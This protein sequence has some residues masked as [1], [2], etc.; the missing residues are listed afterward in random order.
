MNS[1]QARQKLLQMKQELEAR[2]A[3]THKHIYNKEE[4]VSPKFSEQ[5]KETENDQLVYTLDR[6]AQDELKRINHA[7]LRIEAGQ[8]F[9]CSRCGTTINAERLQAIPYT[10][11]CIDCA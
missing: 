7:L 10:E 1:D 3:R 9:K 8:Y 11:F 6:E 4:A 2:L 5:I